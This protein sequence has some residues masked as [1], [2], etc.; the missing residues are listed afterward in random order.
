MASATVLPVVLANS[1]TEGRSGTGP[2]D[3][4]VRWL[5]SFNA[6]YSCQSVAGD[7]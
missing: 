2:V 3:D 7:G 5:V 4:S 1:P 6:G